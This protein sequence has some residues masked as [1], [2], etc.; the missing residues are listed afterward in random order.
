MSPACDVFETKKGHYTGNFAH[1]IYEEHHYWLGSSRKE[2]VVDLD[3][4][5]IIAILNV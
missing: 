3:M 5:L 4:F 1:R 2:Y